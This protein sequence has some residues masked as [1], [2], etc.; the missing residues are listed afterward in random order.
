[1]ENNHIVRV[2]VY[3][4]EYPTI[5]GM[6]RVTMHIWAPWVSKLVDNK[7]NK[8]KTMWFDHR[9]HIGSEI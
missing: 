8:A 5:F 9:A 7:D 1:M 4:H 3:V 6:Y 2:C